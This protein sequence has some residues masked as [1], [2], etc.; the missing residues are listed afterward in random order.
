MSLASGRRIHCNQWGVLPMGEAIIDRVHELAEKEGQPKIAS[1][2]KFERRLEGALIEDDK[3]DQQDE[4]VNELLVTDEGPKPQILEID[5]DHEPHIMDEGD[6]DYETNMDDEDR[7][8]KLPANDVVNNENEYPLAEPAV[9]DLIGDDIDMEQVLEMDGNEDKDNGEP[10]D[11][12]VGVKEDEHAE[13]A[14]KA[15]T[16]SRAGRARMPTNSHRNMYEREFTHTIL[17]DKSR[18]GPRWKNF[19][20]QDIPPKT[21][22]APRMKNVFSRTTQLIFAQIAKRD[23]YAQVPVNKGVKMHGDKALDALLSE[24]GQIP[25][26]VTFIPQMVSD[27]S[28]EQRKEALHLITMIKEKRC[29]KIKARACVDGRRQRRYIKKEDVA[30]PTIQQESLILSLLIDAR[31][32]RDVST[33]DVVGA[34]LL[35]LMDD[36]VLI[37]LTGTPIDT[38]CNISQEYVKYITMENGKRVLYLRLKK[39]LYGCMQS[40]I[41]W[42]NTFRGRLEEMGFRLNK[43]DPMCGKP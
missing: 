43:Y 11:G 34:Y 28:V 14:D 25:N 26:H 35:A 17:G 42:Y 16:A 30:S 12:D 32:R 39:A 33:A 7:I 23:K 27:L 31:E 15:I 21:R 20:K 22:S 4:D 3:D 19:K 13:E 9:A 40:V 38:L 18:P 37:K 24:Y 10:Q 36:Y 1:N 29:G 5:D 41:L 8:E 2:F 6:D